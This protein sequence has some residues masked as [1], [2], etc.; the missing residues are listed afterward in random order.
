MKK[1]IGIYDYTVILTY[2]GLL[3][4]L[5]GMTLE[6]KGEFLLAL[7]CLGCSLV[8]DTLDGR[9]ARA[10][11]NRTEIEKQFGI[12]IDSLCDVISF[13]VFPAVMFY[14]SGVNTAVDYAL[15][16]FYCLCGVIR[17][18]YFNVLA[19]NKKEGEESVYHGLPIV[20]M[21]IFTPIAY[22]IKLWVPT[23]AFVYVLRLMLLAFGLLYILDVKVK[24]PPMW[25]LSILCL[26]FW[27]PVAV[28]ALVG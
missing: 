19:A 21:G 1:F 24:K 7:I 18:G 5:L 2:A 6:A 15:L 14:A 23:V 4:A 20:T 9:V 12:Q 17:L 3:S 28:I 13:G 16:G 22:M 10:K 26:V 8:C 11:K 27:A 25:I